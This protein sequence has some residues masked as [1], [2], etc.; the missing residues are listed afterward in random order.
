MDYKVIAGKMLLGRTSDY[1]Q[2]V[3]WMNLHNSM[4]VGGAYARIVECE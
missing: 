1:A 3:E 2:A 4:R